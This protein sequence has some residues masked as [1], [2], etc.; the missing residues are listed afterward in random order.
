MP[1]FLRQIVVREQ[2]LLAV[3]AAHKEVKLGVSR[4]D[5]GC[6]FN[7]LL[8][9]SLQLLLV[10]QIGSVAVLPG[11][12]TV[13]VDLRGEAKKVPQDLVAYFLKRT[14]RAFA[15]RTICSL[16]ITGSGPV[17]PCH[18]VLNICSLLQFHVAVDADWGAFAI[19]FLILGRHFLRVQVLIVQTTSFHL[20]VLGIGHPVDGE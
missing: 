17:R 10:F 12:I 13:N 18:K 19:V 5:F 8:E 3:V 16:I 11:G 14:P 15:L 6:L 2:S 7:R 1:D 9:L 20:I 4:V